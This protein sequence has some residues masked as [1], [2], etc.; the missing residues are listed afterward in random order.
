MKHTTK[1]LLILALMATAA[2]S[3]P[4]SSHA[5]KADFAPA[6]DLQATTAGA[7][8]QERWWGVAA[9]F[10]CRLGIRNGSFNSFTGGLCLIALVDAVT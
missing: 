6:A 7:P 8:T 5:R 9:W 3:V 2:S 10:G 1:L 4:V